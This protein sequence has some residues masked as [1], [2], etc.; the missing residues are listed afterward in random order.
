MVGEQSDRA[1]AFANLLKEG[2]IKQDVPVLLTHST[3]AEAIKLFANTY[4]AMR[5]AYFNELDTVTYKC[6]SR[7]CTH[8]AELS[9]NKRISDGSNHLRFIEA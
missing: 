8:L 6:N 2:A 4:L 9:W 5:V 1:Q 7:T 3:E